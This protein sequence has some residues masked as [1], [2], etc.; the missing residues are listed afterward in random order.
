MVSDNIKDIVTK[1]TVFTHKVVN[2]L[3][4]RNHET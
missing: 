2:N 3:T 4:V 1:V